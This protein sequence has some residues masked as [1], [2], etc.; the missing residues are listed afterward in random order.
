MFNAFIFWPILC[1]RRRCLAWIY[2]VTTSKNTSRLFMISTISG[3]SCTLFL[4]H[5][6]SFDAFKKTRRPLGCNDWFWLIT[7]TY[8]K[9]GFLK[10]E[11]VKTKRWTLVDL[12]LVDLVRVPGQMTCHSTPLT[13]M[14]CCHQT[15]NTRVTDKAITRPWVK[16]QIGRN[17]LSFSYK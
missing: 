9:T 7:E 10:V 13:F 17:I 4:G 3:R 8:R 11:I 15:L 1:L 2:D 14:S 5:S 6:W 12:S 16:M